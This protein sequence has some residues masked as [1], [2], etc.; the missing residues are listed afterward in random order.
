[1][2]ERLA[3]IERTLQNLSNSIQQITAVQGGS[4]LQSPTY[5]PINVDEALAHPS[6]PAT[7]RE[8]SSFEGNTSLQAHSLH[9]TQV[10]EQAISNSFAVHQS[11]ELLSALES[12]KKLLDRQSMISSKEFQFPNQATIDGAPALSNK[13]PP[14]TDTSAV[15]K[16]AK[17]EIP[18]CFYGYFPFLTIE[19]LAEMCEMVYSNEHVENV[20][21]YIIVNVILHYLFQEYS[22]GEDGNASNYRQHSERCQS[23]LQTGL[24]TLSLMLPPSQENIVALLLGVNPV[25]AQAPATLDLYL[26]NAG[27]N[28]WPE[29]IQWTILHCPFTPFMVVFCHVIATLSA[30][31]LARLEAF[32][33]SLQPTGRSSEGLDKAYRLFNLFY[34]LAKSYVQ[35]KTGPSVDI[36]QPGASS[37]DLLANQGSEEFDRYFAALGWMPGT[38]SYNTNGTATS[39]ALQPQQPYVEA[40]DGSIPGQQLDLGGWFNSN[41]YFA[42][43]LE[44]DLSDI[45]GMI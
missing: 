42:S 28:I 25:E 29:Y 6:R 22:A 44:E 40:G 37:F 27:R 4:S 20:P 38:T 39:Q 41:Q 1:M 32:V 14:L 18:Q 12:L 45:T 9:A 8:E 19:R 23:N 26:K 35:C 10:A 36:T 7:S 21:V 3:G 30:E 13:M 17:D 11:P 34:V 33:R 43:L 15:L 5:Q 2:E 16:R 24:K 31:D